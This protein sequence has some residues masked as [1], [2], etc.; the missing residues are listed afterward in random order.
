MKKI[1]KI[2]LYRSTKITP[3]PI[4]VVSIFVGEMQSCDV[5]QYINVVAKDLSEQ[6]E[7]WCVICIPIRKGESKIESHVVSKHNPI[8]FK[9]L[10]NKCLQILNQQEDN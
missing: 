3:K 5:A 4:L 10:Q 9:N 1:R 8:S 7:G 2:Q 6:A